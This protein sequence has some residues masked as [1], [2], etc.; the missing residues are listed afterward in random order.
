[1]IA[2]HS[3]RFAKSISQFC[4]NTDHEGA[5]YIL[6]GIL[7]F[8]QKSATG[9]AAEPWRHNTLHKMWRASGLGTSI[10]QTISPCTPCW[11]WCTWEM[12]S[13]QC[14]GEASQLIWLES[15]YI[16]IHTLTHV[17]ICAYIYIYIHLY[18]F[19]YVVCHSFPP[20]VER[21][22]ILKISQLTLGS[23]SFLICV[24]G[25]WFVPIER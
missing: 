19:M 23:R 18:I 11:K 5:T 15:M 21:F 2:D 12:P 22:T 10:C 17:I 20:A 8:A 6:E 4:R 25:T 1:M 3:P 9:L 13:L 24:D 14:S 16:Y 7:I